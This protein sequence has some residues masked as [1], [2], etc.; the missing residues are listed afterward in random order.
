MLSWAHPMT[1][2]RSGPIGAAV[3]AALALLFVTAAVASAQSTGPPP[4]DAPPPPDKPA[5]AAFDASSAPYV[6]ESIVTRYRYEADGTG[7][8][9]QAMRIKVQSTSG[10]ELWGQLSFV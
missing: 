7:T 9:E 10:L 8:F 3:S 1:S 6:I 4:P 2:T 5:P